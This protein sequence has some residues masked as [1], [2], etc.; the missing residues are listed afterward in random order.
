MRPVRNTTNVCGPEYPGLDTRAGNKGYIVA[1]PSM[2]KSERRYAWAPGCAPGEIEMAEA[3]EWLLAM[4][5]EKPR[6]QR[7]APPPG[8]VTD[9]DRRRAAGLLEW[10]ANK[11][12]GTGAGE[13]NNTLFQTAALIGGWVG[14]GYLTRSEAEDA[15][16]EAGLA[17]GLSKREVEMTVGNGLDRGEE[18][19]QG[20]PDD[21]ERK[22]AW[23]IERGLFVEPLSLDEVGAPQGVL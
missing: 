18:N 1:P 2:H 12:A 5:V 14:A 13:R 3:P 8:P 17:C 19:P 6:E 15:L 10:A 23:M 22:R 9:V 21:S 7:T 11:V 4:V 20:L 16:E